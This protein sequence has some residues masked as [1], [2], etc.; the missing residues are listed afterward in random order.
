MMRVFGPASCFISSVVPTA[1]MR[2]RQTATASASGCLRLT[3]HTLPL[4]STRSAFGASAAR[5]SPAISDSEHSIGATPSVVHPRLREIDVPEHDV[6]R[7]AGCGSGHAIGSEGDGVD[8]AKLPVVLHLFPSRLW[9]PQPDGSI[10]TAGGEQSAVG[11]ERHRPGVLTVPCQR[12]PL[13][14]AVNVPQPDC[15][16]GNR[17]NR[18]GRASCRERAQAY[19]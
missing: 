19:G 5:T 1:W 11:R 6:G 4:S 7:V 3:V 17:G 16:T 14:P 10:P 2:S 12:Q 8:T 15:A 18:I 13:S 9:V